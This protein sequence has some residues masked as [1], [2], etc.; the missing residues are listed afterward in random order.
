MKNKL[1]AT[2][3]IAVA[4]VFILA[5][6]ENDNNLKTTA[7]TLKADPVE[8]KSLRGIHGL[9]ALSAKSN[10][11]KFVKEADWDRSFEDQPPLIPH[12]TTKGDITL[13]KNKC[14]DCHSNENWREEEAVK[15]TASHFMTRADER[16]K[17]ASSRRYF[18]TQ[19]HVPQVDRDALVKNSY[20][21]LDD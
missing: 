6:C 20:I 17:K 3:I 21:N 10:M 12:K 11:G 18:C 7:N 8:V 14:L 13:R 2:T 16:L 15:M 4:S 5:S 9:D 19:C 1:L